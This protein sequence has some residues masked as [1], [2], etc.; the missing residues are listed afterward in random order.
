M[1]ELWQADIV[2]AATRVP[3]WTRP[4]DPQPF[5]AWDMAGGGNIARVRSHPDHDPSHVHSAADLQAAAFAEGFE[6]GRTAVED[7]VGEE[8][9]A[10]TQLAA[11]LEV[12]KPQP[13]Q[14]LAMLLSETVERLVRQI[15]GTVDIDRD[16]LLERC[17]KAADLIG[18]EAG[19]M[20]LRLHPEDIA[21]LSDAPIDTPLVAD[22]HLLRGTIRLETDEGWIEDG[23]EAR[24]ERLRA[25]LD[26]M[27]L[28]VREDEIL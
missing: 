21:L 3:P 25:A 27:G 28:A 20:R 13:S 4:L 15:M 14:A 8:R 16:S 11:S 22:P 7:M 9:A 5:R 10:I 18:D 12:L 17:E 19:P 1:S 24:L 2:A 26:Q 23:P 6:A